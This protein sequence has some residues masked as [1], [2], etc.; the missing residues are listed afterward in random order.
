MSFFHI[1]LVLHYFRDAETVAQLR[2]CLLLGKNVG[3]NFFPQ[4]FV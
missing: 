3:L 1:V 2:L 4:V